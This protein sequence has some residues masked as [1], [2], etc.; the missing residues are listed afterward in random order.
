VVLTV[1]A[2]VWV[3]Q[4][5]GTQS[6]GVATRSPKSSNPVAADSGNADVKSP[7]PNPIAPDSGSEIADSTVRPVRY[8]NR[9]SIRPIGAAADFQVRPAAAIT[10]NDPNQAFVNAPS[11]SV[12]VSLENEGGATRKI[13]LPPV[14]FGAQ[15][16]V[17]N[18]KP[19]TYSAN[20][21][22]W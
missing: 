20:S 4:R 8:R 22:I 3:A 7:A 13:S 6:T 18:R 10:Q 17:N 21:R 9:P 5:T 15:N 19:V 2:V 12:E 1:G 14:S 16:L 11:K